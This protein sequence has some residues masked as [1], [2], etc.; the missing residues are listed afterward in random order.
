M[1]TEY[2]LNWETLLHQETK[3]PEVIRSIQ[4]L[5]NIVTVTVL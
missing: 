3:V 5:N 2:L 4:A 1:S